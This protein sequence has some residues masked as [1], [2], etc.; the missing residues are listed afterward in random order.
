MQVLLRLLHGSGRYF[1]AC[2]LCGLVFTGC[3]LVIPQIIRVSVDSFI[4]DQPIRNA[5]TLGPNGEKLELIELPEDEK[6]PDGSLRAY[7][8]RLTT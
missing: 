8:S 5:V 6:R 7:T 2:I 3:E 1:T 4:G